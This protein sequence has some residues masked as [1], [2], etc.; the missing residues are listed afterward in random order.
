MVGEAALAT[1]PRPR[2]APMNTSQRTTDTAR[3]DSELKIFLM[4]GYS[5]NRDDFTYRVKNERPTHVGWAVFPN[6]VKTP[7]AIRNSQRVPMTTTP[8]TN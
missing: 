7:Q 3:S 8:F 4:L 6:L 5:T 1:A 2:L